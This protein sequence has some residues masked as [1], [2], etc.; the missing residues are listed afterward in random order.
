MLTELR[1]GDVVTITETGGAS[2]YETT[3]T[4][5]G[6]VSDTQILDSGKTIRFVIGSGAGDIRVTF[7]NNR[8]ITSPTGIPGQKLSGLLAMMGLLFGSVWI[9]CEGCFSTGKRRK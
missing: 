7:T 1:E 6:N 9:W 2:G 3:P 5:S 4:V 8:E